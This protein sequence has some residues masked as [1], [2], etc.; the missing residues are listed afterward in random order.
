MEHKDSL[1]RKTE[2][3]RKVKELAKIEKTSE[4]ALEKQ[5]NEADYRNKMTQLTNELRIWKEKVTKMQEL[6]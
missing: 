3:Q 1:Q 5:Y 4:I 6:H 2:L